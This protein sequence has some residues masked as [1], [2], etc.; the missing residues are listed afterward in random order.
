VTKRANA[1]VAAFIAADDRAE[2]QALLD[3][4]CAVRP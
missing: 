2:G 3:R 4:P 1:S